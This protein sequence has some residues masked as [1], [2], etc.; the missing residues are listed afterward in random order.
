MQLLQANSKIKFVLTGSANERYL[1]RM[2]L[3]RCPQAINLI[4]LTSIQEMAALLDL[5][6]VVV[7]HD[8]GTLHIACARKRPVVALFAATP[9]VFTGPYPN[10]PQ[11]KT[12]QANSMIEIKPE[13]V[14]TEIVN[15]LLEK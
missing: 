6:R 5:S 7:T 1:A 2:F 13:Q 9:V 4:G 3:K 15:I 11:F 14:Y 8:T 10:L 12:L